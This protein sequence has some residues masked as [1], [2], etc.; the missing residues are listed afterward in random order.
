MV[1]QEQIKAT[2]SANVACQL[3]PPFFGSTHLINSVPY[4]VSALAMHAPSVIDAGLSRYDVIADAQAELEHMLPEIYKTV[5]Y[6]IDDGVRQ[7]HLPTRAVQLV[8]ATQ[9]VAR[10]NVT[11]NISTYAPESAVGFTFTGTTNAALSHE[12][13]LHDFSA[14]QNRK[15]AWTVVHEFMHMMQDIKLINPA[16]P[17]PYTVVKAGIKRVGKRSNHGGWLHEA[18]T[19]RFT[20]GILT[21]DWD[22][23]SLSHAFEM[24]PNITDRKLLQLTTL[25]IPLNDFANCY[26]SE[27]SNENCEH[28][29]KN[30][31]AQFRRKLGM[32]FDDY[33]AA[34]N[35]A[36]LRNYLIASLS[37]NAR[38]ELLQ[39]RQ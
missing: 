11:D 30:L 14:E 15:I 12:L 8:E 31:H 9:K 21:G 24:V 34:G 13:F 38:P 37:A 23:A 18:L 35:L 33:L 26:F 27:D 20:A 36:L 5:Q 25:Q 1:T 32:T 2:L 7:G 39:C 28:Y 10:W 17:N 29:T 16:N 4:E 6:G 3:P 19:D 22:D